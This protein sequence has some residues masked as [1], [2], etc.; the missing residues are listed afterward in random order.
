MNAL[1]SRSDAQKEKGRVAPA[2]GARDAAD[3]VL[4]SVPT[5]S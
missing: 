4:S 1:R 5:L 2:F 3:G